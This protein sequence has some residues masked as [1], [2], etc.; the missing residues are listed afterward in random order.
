M[1]YLTKGANMFKC[2]CSSIGKIL[3]EPQKKSDKLSKTCIAYLKEWYLENKYG[4]KNEITSKYLEKGISCEAESITLIGII[5]DTI[6]HKNDE[7]FVNNYITGTPD[8]I[9]DLEVIDVKTSWS[10]KTFPFAD[11]D[12]DKAYFWQLQGYMALTGKK[13]SRLVYCL[14]NTP[15]H[16]I[17]DEIRRFCWNNNIIDIDED[18]ENEIRSS[19]IYDQIPLENRIKIFQINRDEEAIDSIYKRV[20]ECREY[21]SNFNF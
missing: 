19:F 18:V 6:Y 15:D 3:T 7:F 14:I 17:N 4:I 9:T 1:K 5:D 8:I 2:R 16:L 20:I 10:I 21:L 13:T 12:Y 11:T